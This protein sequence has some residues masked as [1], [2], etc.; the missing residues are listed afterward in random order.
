MPEV[1]IIIPCF[2]AASTILQTLASVAKQSSHDYEVIVVD[3]ASTDKT[4]EVLKSVSQEGIRILRHDI[5]RGVSASRNDGTEASQGEYITFLDADD[6]LDSSFCEKMTSLAR[7]HDAD[8]V[9]CNGKRFLEDG[10]WKRF[11][12]GEQFF[13]TNGKDYS[14]DLKA[15]PFFDS[16]CCKLYRRAVLHEKNIRFQTDMKFGEDTLFAN[17]AA[18]SSNNI[19]VAKDYCGYLYHYNS[20]S[21]IHTIDVNARLTNLAKLITRLADIFPKDKKGVLL[22]K[23]QEYLWTI[24]KFG[25]E[26]RGTL[27]REFLESDLWSN[28]AK[29]VI[30]QYGKPKQRMMATL[31]SRNWLWCIRFW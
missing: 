19:V 21:C 1:S 22:R 24:K 4:S 25:K 28:L 8:I 14:H 18:A 17:H 23:C 9:A 5:N 11:M 30:M 7:H 12:P 29:P 26:N 27:L 31:L 3:D 15:V 10:T 16:S 20:A 2:N 6:E 13:V